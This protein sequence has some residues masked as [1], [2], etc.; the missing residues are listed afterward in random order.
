MQAGDASYPSSIH[1]GNP[2]FLRQ[3]DRKREGGSSFGQF[4][5]NL[6]EVLWKSLLVRWKDFCYIF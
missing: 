1:I 3:F 4:A 2:S 6:P 5:N